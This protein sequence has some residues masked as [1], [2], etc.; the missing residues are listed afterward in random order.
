MLLATI[1][2]PALQ[3][4]STGESRVLAHS[5]SFGLNLSMFTS[6]LTYMAVKTPL[7]RG[8][9]PFF[10]KWGPWFL[11]LAAMCLVMIDLT[12]HVVLDAKLGGSALWMYRK[13]E[14]LTTTGWIGVVS[15][16]IGMACLFASVLWFMLGSGRV[17]D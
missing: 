14:H 1:A 5:L 16:W 13:G 10:L 3:G 2:G 6:T 15:T 9:L 12:R 8:R 4:V 11:M 17:R 7:K